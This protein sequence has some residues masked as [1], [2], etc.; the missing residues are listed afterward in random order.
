M[1]CNDLIRA[2]GSSANVL[3]SNAHTTGEAGKVAAVSV[4]RFASVDPAPSGK[5][6]VVRLR[7]KPGESVPLLFASEE[8]SVDHATAADESE[9]VGTELA[10]KCSLVTATIAPDGTGVDHFGA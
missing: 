4:Y 2:N 6:I 9:D 1:P 5:G 3:A 7:G 10:L 8:K